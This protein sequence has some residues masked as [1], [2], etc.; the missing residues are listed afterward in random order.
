MLSCPTLLSIRYTFNII[1]ISQQIDLNFVA[2]FFFFPLL[3]RS[4]KMKFIILNIWYLLSLT[5][6]IRCSS[7]RVIQLKTRE[8]NNE[9]LL[10][11]RVFIVTCIQNAFQLFLFFCP[12]Q[13]ASNGII[14]KKWKERKQVSPRKK[15]KIQ[16]NSIGPPQE[17]SQNSFAI[18]FV[19]HANFI[20]LRV[21]EAK[22]F[23]PL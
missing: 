14:I 10:L 16:K 9:L 20:F 23:E 18:N 7:D 21:E 5:S 1:N 2:S 11:L 17:S 19:W 15:E 12:F 6:Y 4:L 8:N 22:S 13:K 3:S